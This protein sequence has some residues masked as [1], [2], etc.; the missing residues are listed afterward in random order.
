MRDPQSL[1]FLIQYTVWGTEI[2]K[3]TEKEIEVSGQGSGKDEQ[4]ARE[5]IEKYRQTYIHMQ[6]DSRE[7]ED[8]C[9]YGSN[10]NPEIFK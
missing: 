5:R 3:V 8:I 1:Y 7:T 10:P 9:C 6:I 4:M 2:K